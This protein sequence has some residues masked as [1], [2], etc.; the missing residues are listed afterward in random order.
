[1]AFCQERPTQQY[2]NLGVGFGAV[3]QHHQLKDI[4][5]GVGDYFQIQFLNEDGSSFFLHNEQSGFD[6]TIGDTHSHG[7]QNVSA[8][9]AA[10]LGA[11]DSV[12]SLMVGGA[13]SYVPA[14][15]GVTGGNESISYN[16]S[17][18]PMVELGGKWSTAAGPTRMCFGLSYRLLRFGQPITLTDAEGTAALLQNK[19]SMNFN[20]AVMKLF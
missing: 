15:I 3:Y 5:D 2:A 18:S 1:M 20:I 6:L 10:Y 8:I 14:S 16:H 12:L 9:G 4:G 11:Y 17:S 7:T 13:T 19:N